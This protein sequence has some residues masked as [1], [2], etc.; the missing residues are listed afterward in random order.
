K[1]P[2]FAL[3]R[4]RNCCCTDSPR[5]A[6]GEGLGVRA[7]NFS[8]PPA[9]FSASTLTQ[10]QPL[11]PARLTTS[12][13]SSICLREN[14]S[15]APL[16]LSA[17]TAHAAQV[18]PDRTVLAAPRDRQNLLVHVGRLRERVPLP[19]GHRARHQVIACP[20]RRALAHQRRL[21]LVEDLSVKVVADD[22]VD[23]MP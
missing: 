23:P 1:S 17:R 11:P 18:A 9:N 10:A 21:D 4:S 14:F 2:A 6:G 5:P 16:A 3:R 12:A 22:L 8:M 20:F 15:A 19:Q 13:S 7:R